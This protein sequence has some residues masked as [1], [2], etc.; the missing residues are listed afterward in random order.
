MKGTRIWNLLFNTNNNTNSHRTNKPRANKED[1]RIRLKLYYRRSNQQVELEDGKGLYISSYSLNNA[2][3]LI[4]MQNQ[5][6]HWILKLAVLEDIEKDK[7]LD[8]DL[9]V[10]LEVK[11]EIVDNQIQSQCKILESL[12]E[13]GSDQA[14]QDG[15]LL[16]DAQLRNVV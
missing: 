4:R 12:R 16:M 1:L 6:Q 5:S 3:D 2:S 14:N 11:I 15:V 10:E 7:L 8:S 9:G 13:D